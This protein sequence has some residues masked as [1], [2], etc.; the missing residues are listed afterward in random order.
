VAVA[1]LQNIPLPNQ[2][3]EVQNYVVS[4]PF[5]ND[6]DQFLIR[7]DQTLGPNDNLFGRITYAKLRTFQPYGNTNLNETL[8]P[9]FGYDITTATHNA[10]VNYTHIFSPSLINELRVGYLRVVGGQESQNAGVDFAGESGLQGVTRDLSKVGF[11]TMSFSDAYNIMGDPQ[12]LITRRNNSFDFFNNLSW[13]RGAHSMRF[14]AYLFRLRFNP[15]GQ[16]S[17]F[18]TL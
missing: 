16:L 13:I 18:A 8:V 1:F 4:S 6:H 12:T 2:P 9:G 3:G 7:G 17:F 15:R 5:R 11:P 10:A 14:G